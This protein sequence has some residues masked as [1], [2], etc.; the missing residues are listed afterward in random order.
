MTTPVCPTNLENPGNPGK[1]VCNSCLMSECDNCLNA[2]IDSNDCSTSTRTGPKFLGIP[3]QTHQVI[4]G[5]DPEFA[6]I[7]YF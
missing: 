2:C 3:G 6:S 4:Y 7:I 5:S 1:D